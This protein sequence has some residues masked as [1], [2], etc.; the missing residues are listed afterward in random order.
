[1][2]QDA[3]RFYDAPRHGLLPL[4]EAK[5]VHQFDHRWASYEDSKPD[6]T[7]LIR[8]FTEREKESPSRFIRPR[9]WVDSTDVEERL[10][11]RWERSWLL[12]WRNITD[13]KTVARTVVASVVPRA[14]VGHKYSLIFTE[15][16]ARDNALLLANL[17]SFP[18]DFCARQKIGGVGLDYY[19][20][21]Q[22]PI[23]F[24]ESYSIAAFWQADAPLP[25]WIAARVLELSYTAWDL[26]PFAQDLG[27]D[28]PPFRW[29]VDRR[30]EIRCELDAAYFH[31][32]EI[33]RD[34]VDYIMSTFPIVQRKDEAAHGA[35]RTRD[36]I[37]EIYD[38]MASGEWVSALDPLPA[39]PRAAHPRSPRAIE[40]LGSEIESQSRE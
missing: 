4:Y 3:G 20:M 10:G 5:M 35:Y 16:P 37:L 13:N 38:G 36:R 29:D 1:M 24:P 14:G 21:K 2:A 26:E 27:Y 32:Y 15:R 33:E 40:P 28:G 22:F 39:D 7:P 25:D 30:C 6:G 19:L 31:L 18:L 17:N 12:G 9:Y 8:D 23:L 11:G 34:D